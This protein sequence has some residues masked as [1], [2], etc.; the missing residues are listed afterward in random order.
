M[1]PFLLMLPPQVLHGFGSTHQ[2]ASFHQ[3]VQLQFKKSYVCC[4]LARNWRSFPWRDDEDPVSRLLST[5]HFHQAD[6]SSQCCYCSCR[7]LLWPT[8]PIM[9]CL[10]AV[11]S[12]KR[13]THSALQFLKRRKLANMGSGLKKKATRKATLFFFC[14]FVLFSFLLIAGL[15]SL[16]NARS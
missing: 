15:S 14:L 7:L 5:L 6:R 9:P 10:V 2:A 4:S 8:L 3:L 11:G 13:T 12:T 1:N 16:E